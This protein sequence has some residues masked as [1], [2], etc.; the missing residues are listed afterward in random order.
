[1]RRS[2]FAGV[3]IMAVMAGGGAHAQTSG[4][5]GVQLEEIIVTA[6]RREANLQKTAASVAAISGA[7]VS[8]QGLNTI[9]D[10]LKTVPNVI[11]QGQHKGFTPAIRGLGSDLPPGTGE[12]SVA[13]NADGVYN[14]RAESG[15]AGYYDVAR[16]EVLRGPQG[17]L[18]GRNATAGVVNVV[19]ND[20]VLD[21][22][23]GAATL[24]VGNYDLLRGEGVVN[25]PLTETTAVRAAFT[26]INRS[27]YLSNGQNDNVVQALR[28]KILH[29]PNDRLSVLAG[30]ETL[31]LGGKGN[32]G[33]LAWANGDTPSDPWSTPA[34]LLTGDGKLTDTA[35]SGN[36]YRAYKVWSQIT[37]DAGFGVLTVLPAF[38]KTEASAYGCFDNNCT[39]SSNDPKNL[40]QISGEIR[41][42]SQPSSPVQWVVGLYHYNNNMTNV[43]DSI[44]PTVQLQTSVYHADSEAVFGQVVVPLS[45]A[46]RFTAGARQTQDWKKTLVYTTPSG[47]AMTLARGAHTWRHFDWKL[48]LDYDL[49]P[50]SLLYATLSTGYRPGGFNTYLTGTSAATF[51]PETV[52]AFEL[53]SKTRL[54]D[55]RLQVNG[56]VYYYDYKNYQAF[57]F[58]VALPPAAPPYG[59]QFLFYNTAISNYGAEL[60]TKALLS[61]RDTLNLSVAY[62]HATFTDDLQLHVGGFLP[63]NLTSL[64]GNPIPHSPEWTLNAGLQHVFDLPGG[65]RLTARADARYVTGQYV[66]PSE[67]PKAWQPAYVV[68][69]LSATYAAGGGD[70]SLTAYLKNLSNE[71]IKVNYINDYALVAAPRT[72]GLVLTTRFGGS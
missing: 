46:L 23:D 64:K 55:D 61:D 9:D 7:D 17:T 21:R 71:A 12:G 58:Y 49:A 63:Q 50:Q 28:L 11:V 6:E 60:E 29:R 10:V 48:G 52:T 39:L 20:P 40:E 47:G 18:Y 54:L 53:G 8:A 72:F 16:V 22:Y 42:A 30:M 59:P 56:A 13:V 26:S 33:V 38:S 32:S 25:L 66:G 65:A 36:D 19:S 2:L 4:A 67:E 5:P 37:W 24:E 35:K 15:Q 41:L 27:G 62:L 1:M 51:D 14:I 68:G 34:T 69:D 44:N 3:A 43:A 31:K 57:D 45:R 70:W